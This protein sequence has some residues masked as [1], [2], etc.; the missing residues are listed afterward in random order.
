M[1]AKPTS[2][3]TVKV[4]EKTS[5]SQIKALLI[6]PYPPPPAFKIMGY[7]LHLVSTLEDRINKLEAQ[8]IELSKQCNA[9]ATLTAKTSIGLK[10]NKITKPK[11]FPA[12]KPLLKK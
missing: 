12:I 10:Q 4:K 9:P 3:P 2:K 6:K 1:K 7:Y 5:A 8:V 11:N